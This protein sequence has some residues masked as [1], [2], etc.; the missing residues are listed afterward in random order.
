ME[1][2]HPE[3][4]R[5]GYNGTSR[6][7]RRGRSAPQQ[8]YYAAA[9]RIERQWHDH[10][11]SV[12]ESATAQRTRPTALFAFQRSRQLQR[13]ADGPARTLYQRPA[14][15]VKLHVVEVLE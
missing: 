13:V 7:R 15:A 4:V 12:P 3:A 11:Q 6:L 14:G 1:L 8:H 2:E 5:E 10:S 9:E